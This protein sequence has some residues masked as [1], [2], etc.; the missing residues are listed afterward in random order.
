MTY[1]LEDLVVG[2][3]VA[4]SALFSAWRLLS[5]RLRLRVLDILEPAL[6]NLPGPPLRQLRSR[7]LARLAGG[8]SACAAR[9]SHL[10]IVK[11]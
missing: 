8:C 9:P 3:L 1:L 11:R 6:C 5:V 4:A 10:R 2:I 7:T